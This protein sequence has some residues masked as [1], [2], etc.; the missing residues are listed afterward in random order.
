MKRT[1][2]FQSEYQISLKLDEKSGNGN[3]ISDFHDRVGS[4]DAI[5]KW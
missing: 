2:L 3:K 5:D 1:Q 4:V